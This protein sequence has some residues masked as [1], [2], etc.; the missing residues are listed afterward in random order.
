MTVTRVGNQKHYQANAAA[1]VFAELAGLV[2][3]SIGLALPLQDVLMPLVLPSVD[4]QR[5][6]LETLDGELLPVNSAIS[7]LNREI[8]LLR[9]YRTRLV[10]DVVTGKLDAREAAAK[11]PE[12]ALPDSIEYDAELNIDLDASE[13]E[14]EV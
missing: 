8:E 10:A 12:E 1:P 13:E 5:Q 2:R 9:E 7:R 4:R 11:L 3:K 6:I 14:A